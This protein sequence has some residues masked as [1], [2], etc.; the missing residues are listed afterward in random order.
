VNKAPP[1]LDL[2]ALK[3]QVEGGYGCPVAGVLPHSNDMMSLAS[4]GTFA[5][6]YP[7]HQLTSR[8]RDI[9]GEVIGA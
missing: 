6:R 5:L 9:A 7:D 2:E 4:D 8:L 3:T 1:D